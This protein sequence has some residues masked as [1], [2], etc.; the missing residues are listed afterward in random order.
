[1]RK[2]TEGLCVNT[3]KTVLKRRIG[4]YAFICMDSTPA[5]DTLQTRRRTRRH[6][7]AAR[8]KSN[9]R[10]HCWRKS[11]PRVWTRSREGAFARVNL[12]SFDD[13]SS[14]VNDDLSWRCCDSAMLNA[15]K[16]ARYDGQRLWRIWCISVAILKMT[17]CLSGSH[18]KYC[19]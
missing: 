18:A 9:E 5:C 16:S 8:Q 6:S 7:S 19:V 15:T 4:L 11:V 13:S 10:K 2:S 14:M 3:R 12:C 17:Q 1:M